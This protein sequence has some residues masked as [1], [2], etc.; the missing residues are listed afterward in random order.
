MNTF[1]DCF[2]F[3]LDQNAIGISLARY[4]LDPNNHQV[5][6]NTYGSPAEI[7]LLEKQLNNIRITALHPDIIQS[8]CK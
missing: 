7:N 8:L 3:E 2:T 1:V 5:V 4:Q 6:D